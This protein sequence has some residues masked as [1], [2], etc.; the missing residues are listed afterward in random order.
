MKI[1]LRAFSCNSTFDSSETSENFSS[2]VFHNPCSIREDRIL[3][4]QR[5]KLIPPSNFSTSY[6]VDD[7]GTTFDVISSQI[8][9]KP[10]LWI[11][12]ALLLLLVG[13]KHPW[14]PTVVSQPP[15]SPCRQSLLLCFCC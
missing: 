1:A 7:V 4:F 8:T 9:H 13:D 11:L 2:T 12:H 14:W 6:F 15:Y 10:I 5:L 3:I